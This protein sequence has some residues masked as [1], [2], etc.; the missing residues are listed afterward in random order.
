MGWLIE[1]PTFLP[2]SKAHLSA[3]EAALLSRYG[4]VDL[5]TFCSVILLFH[6]CASWWMEGRYSKE[7]GAVEGERASVPRSEGQ[8]SSYYILFAL[9]TSVMMVALKI[10]LAVYDIKLWNCELILFFFGVIA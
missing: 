7:G 10:T 4:L 1:A 5:S 9:G 2:N 8:R 6:V 3:G